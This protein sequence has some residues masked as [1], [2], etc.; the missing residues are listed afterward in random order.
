MTRTVVMYGQVVKL[1]GAPDALC[2]GCGR[3]IP[4]AEWT[5]LNNGHRIWP[6]ASAALMPSP[7]AYSTGGRMPH[8]DGDTW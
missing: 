7:D 8:A 5:A 2:D 3:W 6:R 1:E 4:F